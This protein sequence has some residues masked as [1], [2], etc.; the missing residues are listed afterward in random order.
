VSGEQS[1]IVEAF[2]D[3]KARRAFTREEVRRLGQEAGREYERGFESE[4]QRGITAG[5]ARRAAQG[6]Q[7]GADLGDAAGAEAGKRTSEGLT[8]SL[9]RSRG[10]RRRDGEDLGK[11]LG[12]AAGLAA[13]RS[14]SEGLSARLKASYGSFS[15]D[16]ARLGDVLGAAA[17]QHAA[18]LTRKAIRRELDA[19]AK[20]R[21]RETALE[22]R[23]AAAALRAQ[24]KAAAVAAR[25]AAQ[26]ARQR[27]AAL[28]A[29]ARAEA[30]AAKEAERAQVARVSRLAKISSGIGSATRGGVLGVAGIGGLASSAA[31]LGSVLA[32][33]VGAVAQLSGALAL[34]PAAGVAA[35]VGLAA[36][37]I[38]VHDV[39]DALSNSGDPEKYAEALKKLSPAA[40][41]FTRAVVGLKPELKGLRNE[42][43]EGLFKGL[44]KQ[45]TA[46][47]SRY[48]PILQ[49][50]LTGVAKGFNG[51]A[52]AV[53]KFLDSSKASQQVAGILDNTSR[54]ST[55]LGKAFKPAVQGLLDLTSVG[56]GFLPKLTENIGKA[57]TRLANFIDRKHRNGDLRAFIQ[58]GIDGLKDLGSVATGAGRI[59]GGIF[60][61]GG[62]AN[63]SGLQTLAGLL[64]QVADQIGKP[65]FQKG[66]GNFFSSIGDAGSSVGGALPKVADALVALEPALSKI[67]RGG[68]KA[69]GS[70]LETVASAATT[71][72]PALSSLAGIF[73]KVAPHAG[74]VTAGLLALKGVVG[75]LKFV[76]FI[77]GLKESAV[78]L[79]GLAI[80]QGALNIVMSANPIG[81]VVVGLAALTAGLIVAYKKS[82]TFRNIVQAVFR[83]TATAILSQ[84]SLIIGAFG[85]F[86][87]VLGHLPGKAGSAFRSAQ[88]S[89]QSAKA[90]VDGL[91]DAINRVKS[92]RVI[93]SVETEKR[94]GISQGIS[95][96]LS[97]R[98]PAAGAT[99]GYVDRHGAIRRA[100]GGLIDPRLGGPRQDNVPLLVSGGEFVMNAFATSQPGV[101]Q[102]LRKINATNQY[103]QKLASGGQVARTASVGLS[104]LS[105]GQPAR[106]ERLV[107][108]KTTPAGTGPQRLHREDLDYLAQTL[109]AGFDRIHRQQP[110]VLDSGAI[111]GAV[112]NR[113]GRF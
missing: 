83:V 89:A 54:A 51:G 100:V 16:G 35:G 90:K 28:K 69:L 95:D 64:G 96:K 108:A 8:Q 48:I 84:I 27:A 55:N 44:D 53:G 62:G 24:E 99:G 20:I 82:Q 36:V 79:R 11:T 104:D 103:P 81:L 37:K 41:S 4:S 86:F 94:T 43:Q 107:A 15:K 14:T 10:R 110:I 78:L 21:A 34:L 47:G 1:R 97:G 7:I 101:L 91:V 5:K 73:E 25:I 63:T 26:E 87:G 56:S 18:G 105:D 68:G 58:G 23:A 85:S 17:G 76:N 2:I 30:Q 113:G 102:L 75:A 39:G 59:L 19:E 111:A 66:L 32:G 42:V 70:I 77:A 65:T 109:L 38:G 29:Q 60:S 88:R 45:V 74:A 57:S 52:V 49:R 33:T 72:A 31:G 9:A 46:L 50:G 67:V 106:I 22:Q 112:Y 61:A 98:G 40:R 3:V 12:A 92:K 13:G 80:A 6:K 93:I 71:A